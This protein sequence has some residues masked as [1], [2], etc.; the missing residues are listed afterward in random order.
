MN[1][2]SST[3]LFFLCYVDSNAAE[4]KTCKLGG[5]IPNRPRREP[6]LLSSH[7]LYLTSQRT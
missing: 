7:M 1:T 3:E 5:P 2:T 4:L 6:Y